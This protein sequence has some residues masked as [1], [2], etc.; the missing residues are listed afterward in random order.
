VID[1]GCGVNGFSYCYLREELGDVDYVGIEAAGQLVESMN[2]YFEREGF[3]AEAVVGD[4]FDVENVLKILRE[5]KKD[6]VVFLFQVID[7]LEG[8]E[9]DFS[10]EFLSEISKECE[11][12]VLSLSMES[13][14]GR[15]KFEARRKWLMDFLKENF[16]VVRD[17]VGAGEKIIIL[18]NKK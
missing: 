18:K 11:W 4:L 10:K 16:V 5:Q 6:R 7:A 2:D 3:S 13:L 1:L 12:I 17:F 15:K 9:R 14:G 8:L